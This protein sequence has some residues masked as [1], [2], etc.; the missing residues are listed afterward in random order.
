MIEM[1][2]HIRQSLSTKLSLDI[3]II[4]VIIFT[5]SLGFLFWQSRNIIRQEAIEE[6]T[7]VLDN[8]ALRVKGCLMEVE[9]A[10]R[11]MLW[12]ADRHHEMD[13]LL[14]F[15]RRVVT[16]HPNVNGCSITMEPDYYPGQKY[17]FSAYSVR[18]DDLE[19]DQKDSVATVREANYD[20]YDKVWYK[21]PRQKNTAC[22]GIPSTTSM[23][24]HSPVLK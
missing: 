3:L 15:S 5:L 17:G 14:Q 4:V 11:N 8:T 23:P 9:T 21:T 1:R 13:S 18:I 10:T 6:A 2:K 22:W 7:H 19:S 12:L 16:L 20:Y 24:A